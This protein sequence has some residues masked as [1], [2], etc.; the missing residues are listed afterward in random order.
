[1]D[2]N[3]MQKMIRKLWKEI[4]KNEFISYAFWGFTTTVL[5]VVI[6][7]ILCY[8]LEYWIAN[9]IAIVACKIYSYFTNKFFVFKSHCDNFAALIKELMMY[10]LTTG[11]S[12]MVD[13][14]GVL[15]CVEILI[16]GQQNA[17]YIITVV[18]ILVNYV[19]R[20]KFVFENT[21]RENV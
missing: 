2:D 19:L 11:F 3:D 15:F 1:M 6:Y 17:K 5:N 21:N 8:I 9:I 10:I 18:V 13:F 12:G 20:K 14:F 4:W 7:S 16:V